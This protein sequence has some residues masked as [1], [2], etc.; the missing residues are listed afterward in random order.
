[1]AAPFESELLF[2]VDL[3]YKYITSALSASKLPAQPNA[4]MVAGTSISTIASSTHN[5]TYSLNKVG[6]SSISGEDDKHSS[7]T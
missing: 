7:A 6:S 1:M 3:L 2:E 5:L 4:T